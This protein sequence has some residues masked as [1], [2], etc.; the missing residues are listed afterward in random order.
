M[1]K[2]TATKAGVQRLFDRAGKAV[3]K[4]RTSTV[5]ARKAQLLQDLEGFN[6][7][8]LIELKEEMSSFIDL[9]TLSLGEVE[10]MTESQAHTLMTQF[11]AQRDIGEFMDVCRGRIK[12]VAFQHITAAQKIAGAVDPENTNGHIDVPSMGKRFC[13]EAAGVGDP[14]INEVLLKSILGDKWSEVYVEEV[15]PE[16]KTYVLSMEKLMDLVDSDPV[17]MEQIRDA[18]IPGIPKVAKLMVRDL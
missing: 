1:A 4:A 16:T 10:L 3:A 13:R 7:E 17:V 8:R 9:I 2:A 6:L 14:S 15:I 11:L 18:L 12:D 5:S